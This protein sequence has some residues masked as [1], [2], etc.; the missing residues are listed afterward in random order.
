MRKFL[1]NLALGEPLALVKELF[2]FDESIKMDTL[3]LSNLDMCVQNM[4]IGFL[5][6]AV[7]VDICW[8]QLLFLSLRCP[9]MV[10]NMVE[11]GP[12]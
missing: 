6:H 7:R 9:I 5:L 12:H 10:E 3:M 4:F 8:F 1:L 11:G 2:F